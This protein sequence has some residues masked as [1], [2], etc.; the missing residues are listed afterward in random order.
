MGLAAAIAVGSV[1]LS[2]AYYHCDRCEGGF[3]PRDRAYGVEGSTLSPAV[4]RMT[5]I[6]AARVSFEESEELLRELA[7]VRVNAKH[8]ERSAEALGIESS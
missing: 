4:L 5:G 2:R 1:S 8:V 3:F 7:G 6:T